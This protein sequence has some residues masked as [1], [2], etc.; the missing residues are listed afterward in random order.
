MIPREEED[1][2]I[3]TT[4]PL[5]DNSTI[6]S[7]PVDVP[8]LLPGK[9]KR[10]LPK[11]PITIPFD[12]AEKGCDIVKSGPCS[13]GLRVAVVTTNVGDDSARGDDNDALRVAKI[14]NKDFICERIPS[15]AIHSP[16]SVAVSTPIPTP[17]PVPPS[18]TMTMVVQVR[19]LK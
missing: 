5:K 8:L 14:N 9:L 16:V 11:S 4:D 13:T 19:F 17:I 6:S 18:S 15:P 3:L 7:T 1:T 12:L 2:S 10:N